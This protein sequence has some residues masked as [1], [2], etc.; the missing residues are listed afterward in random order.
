MKKAQD[1]KATEI[2]E[3]RK[4]QQAAPS[5]KRSRAASAKKD[6]KPIDTKAASGKKQVKNPKSKDIKKSAGK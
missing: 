4:S 6:Q 3:K 1:V 2:K 5:G